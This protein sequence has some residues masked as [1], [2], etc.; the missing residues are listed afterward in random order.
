MSNSAEKSMG[1]D[2]FL[3]IE[4]SELLDEVKTLKR[5]G[6]AFLSGLCIPGR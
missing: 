3:T 2:P 6:L 4:A 1:S 5:R